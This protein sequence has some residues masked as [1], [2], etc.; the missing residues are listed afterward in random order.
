MLPPAGR[1]GTL[2]TWVNGINLTPGIDYIGKV[3]NSFFGEDKVVAFRCLHNDLAHQRLDVQFYIFDCDVPRP[4]NFIQA[5]EASSGQES[6]GEQSLWLSEL[7]GTVQW[8]NVQ[9]EIMV[10]PDDMTPLFSSS[11]RLPQIRWLKGG[12]DTKGRCFKYAACSQNATRLGY[13]GKGIRPSK[14]QLM[15]VTDRLI[16]HRQMPPGGEGVLG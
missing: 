6:A 9:L 8:E 13:I 12:I 16:S 1:I 2:I 3:T 7:M 5:A 4:A 15:L 10:L 14:S 11:A